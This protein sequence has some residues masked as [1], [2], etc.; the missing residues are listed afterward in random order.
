VKGVIASRILPPLRGLAAGGWY[1]GLTPP[2]NFG[3]AL[4]ANEGVEVGG[5]R[6][7]RDERD[8]D[9]GRDLTPTLELTR[10]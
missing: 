9:D 1:L 10:V 3:Q 6:D 4:R 5:L 7:E 2:A 8:E